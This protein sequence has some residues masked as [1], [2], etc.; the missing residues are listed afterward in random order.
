MRPRAFHVAAL[1]L[2]SL[3]LAALAASPP[4]DAPSDPTAKERAVLAE[5]I[6]VKRLTISSNF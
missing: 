2:P 3:A 5:R 6:Y 4:A 1:A